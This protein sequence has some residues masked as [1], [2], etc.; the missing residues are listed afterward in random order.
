VEV[1]PP[2]LI[3]KGRFDEIFFVDLP[4]EA[5]RKG[6]FDLHL[7]KRKLD[8]KS[9]DLAQLA[10][11]SAGYSGAEIEA[12]VQSAMYSAFA[13]KQAV[14]T[15]AVLSEL[16]FTVPLSRARMEEVSRLRAWARERAVP[17]SA[18]EAAASRA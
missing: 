13:E 7:R 4:T 15:D 2:E 8:P 17:A 14:T 10:K 11:A 12:A 9:F 1:L 5:E 6:I 3:R 16:K 18:P